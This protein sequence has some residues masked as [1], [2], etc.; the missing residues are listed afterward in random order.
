MGNHN[1]GSAIKD[2][3]NGYLMLINIKTRALK[4]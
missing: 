3:H 4:H 2:M 1:M